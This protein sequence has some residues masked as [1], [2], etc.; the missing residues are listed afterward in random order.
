MQIRPEHLSRELARGIAPLYV[1]HGDE[2]LLALEAGDAIRA[3]ARKAGCEQRDVFVAD[4]GFKWDAFLG[5]N[6]NL[7][8][9]GERKL[10]DLRIP[11]GKPGPEGA[12]ALERYAAMPNADNVTL[13]TLPRIDRAAQ[14][15]PWFVALAESAVVIPI[16]PV[17]RDQ[18]PAW[19]A[20]R[21]KAQGQHAS[22]DT[23]AFLAENCEGNL[24][25]ARQEIDK[26]GL[27]LPQG[28]L[29]L[30]DVES[31]VADVARFEVSELA[32]A[33]LGGDA[34][35]VVRI[36]SVLEAEGEAITRILWQLGEDLHALAGVQDALA[37]GI[38]LAT[39]MRNARAWG[40]RQNAL[41]RAQR[42]IPRA[43]MPT[44]LAELARLDAL[45]KGL[46]N[47]NA[48]EALTALALDVA[49]RPI[50]APAP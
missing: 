2:P 7:G 18:L 15:A 16:Y 49:G 28:E 38:P 31:A 47:G 45:A 1:I 21:L 44:L 33:W 8:L 25:A 24:L 6:A 27:L 41:E 14:N 40:R 9:F 11:S 32:E 30:A 35:R 36:L 48:W 3:A 13:I 19:L 22:D 17:E 20:A 10:V 23:L 4:A 43:R 39:A 12:K 34:E 5:A 46:G 50:R 29:K 26:L 42:R 37:S